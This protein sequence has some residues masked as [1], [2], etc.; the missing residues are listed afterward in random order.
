MDATIHLNHYDAMLSIGEGDASPPHPPAP[1][2][3]GYVS[4]FYHRGGHGDVLIAEPPPGEYGPRFWRDPMR[5]VWVEIA[6]AWG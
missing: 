1:P 2:L 4:A 6:E 5:R 3:S